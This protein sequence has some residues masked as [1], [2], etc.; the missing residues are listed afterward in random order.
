M[1]A[2]Y[3]FIIP[4]AYTVCIIRKEIN[5][6]RHQRHAC[7]GGR[8]RM[9]GRYLRIQE[10]GC[11]KTF[12]EKTSLLAGNILHLSKNVTPPPFVKHLDLPSGTFAR[13]KVDL[14]LVRK[15]FNCFSFYNLDLDRKI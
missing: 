4:R 15:D 6:A 3:D 11:V 8:V 14:I 1:H 5:Q 12:G 9:F 2:W 13:S 7:S 10:G